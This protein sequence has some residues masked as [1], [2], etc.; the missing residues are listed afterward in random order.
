MRDLIRKILKEETNKNFTN[1]IQRLMALDLELSS[2]PRAVPKHAQ[3]VS[4]QKPGRK[5]VQKKT[6][7]MF[8]ILLKIILIMVTQALPLQVVIPLSNL[9]PFLVF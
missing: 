8:T 5:K 3:D 6:S 7:K 4:T 1:L 9:K 2:G